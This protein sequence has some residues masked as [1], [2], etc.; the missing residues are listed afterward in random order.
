MSFEDRT[1]LIASLEAGKAD[2]QL[3]P[4]GGKPAFQMVLDHS[5]QGFYGNPRHGGN[6]DYAS[7]LMIG[8]PPMPVRGRQHYEVAQTYPEK[9]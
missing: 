3:L 9:S 2:P 5:L 4:G 7:W 6:K 1:A 8:V